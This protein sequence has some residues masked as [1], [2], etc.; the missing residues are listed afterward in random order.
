MDLGSRR[1]VPH[2]IIVTGNTVSILHWHCLII[3]PAIMMEEEGPVI[4]K[5]HCSLCGACAVECPEEGPKPHPLLT[6]ELFT[7]LHLDE[8]RRYVLRVVERLS[9]DHCLRSSTLIDLRLHHRG[10]LVDLD[11]QKYDSDEY[12]NTCR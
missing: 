6:R 8:E 12:S 10:V 1:S 5:K 7:Q 9:L 2:F 11:G 3:Q 4:I